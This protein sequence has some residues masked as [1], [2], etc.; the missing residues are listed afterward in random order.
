MTVPSLSGSRSRRQARRSD[1]SRKTWRIATV[2]TA[3]VILA[4]CAPSHS[5]AWQRGY[6]YAQNHIAVWDQYHA[7]DLQE[8]NGYTPG[9]WCSGLAM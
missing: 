3:S 8:G 4:G 5:A 6:R 2:I 1:R 7:I 9:L